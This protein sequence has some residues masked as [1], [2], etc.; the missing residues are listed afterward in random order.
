MKN[1]SFAWIAALMILFMGCKHEKVYNQIVKDET[2]GKDI[3]IGYVNV[4]GLKGE[5]FRDAYVRGLSEYVA[6]DSTVQAFKLLLDKVSFRI[7]MGTWCSDSEE[8]VPRFLNILFNAEFDVLNPQ[9]LEI[10]CVDRNKEAGDIKVA[11]YKADRVPTFIVYRDGREI[12]RIV[13][14]FKGKPEADLLE[15]L[16]NY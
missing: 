12:G 9:N 13:E 10:I 3:F 1:N 6:H 14:R 5:I 15:I 4:D 16:K 8:E 2:T 7:I 11:R